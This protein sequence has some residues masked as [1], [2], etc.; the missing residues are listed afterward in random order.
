MGQRL[1][2]A[3]QTLGGAELDR[4]ISDRIGQGHDDFYVLVPTTAP[5]HE[6]ADS[7][8][9]FSL[10]G[11]T[12]SQ[13]DEMRRLMEERDRQYEEA[14]T[15]AQ[16]RAEQRLV[17]MLDRIRSLG[18][19]ADGEVGDED[20]AAAVEQVLDGRDFDEIIIS[21]LPATSSR[22]LK[23]DLPS[24]VGRM[25]DLPVTTIEAHAEG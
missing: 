5:K 22:W 11:L 14:L 9:G 19:T 18:G 25:T 21:T 12:L 23:M 6:A 15:E 4:T 24:K 17:L 16:R 3:N 7:L 1:V 8:Q 20:P 2:V 13:I 10:D